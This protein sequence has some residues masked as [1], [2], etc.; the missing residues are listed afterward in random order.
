MIWIRF[1][2]LRCGTQIDDLGSKLLARLLLD[3]TSHRRADAPV[4]GERDNAN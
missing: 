1:T 4:V 2:R 3:A